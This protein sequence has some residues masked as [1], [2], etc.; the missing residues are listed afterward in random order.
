[1][2][3]QRQAVLFEF[4]TEDV[5]GASAVGEQVPHGDLRGQVLVR[6]VGQVRADG[7]IQRQQ[8]GLDQLQR[9][10]GGEHLVHR[11]DA[12]LGV[13]RVRRA[14]LSVGKAPGVLEQ[15][16]TVAGHEHGA[17]ELVGPGERPGA[18]RQRRHRLGFAHSVQDEIERD[19]TPPR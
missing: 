4:G 12:E 17:G 14:A 16:F 1:M 8:A 13:G 6:V 2:F 15:D 9:R 10:H 11:A 7:V 19:S 3:A 18:G 5:A